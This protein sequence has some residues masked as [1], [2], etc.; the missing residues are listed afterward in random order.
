MAAAVI[1]FGAGSMPGVPRIL[2]GVLILAGIALETDTRENPV[3]GA[4]FHWILA[5]TAGGTVDV[6]ADPE[7]MSAPPA[8]GAI[9]Y[10]EFWLSGR[11]SH[12]VYV[13]DTTTGAVLAKIKVGAGPHGLCVWPQPGRY[14]LGHTGNM[15]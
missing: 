3:T 12:E 9:V 13:F 6:V 10:G 1:T 8:A 4:R 2:S 15:R 11:R 14:S 7:V 5:E